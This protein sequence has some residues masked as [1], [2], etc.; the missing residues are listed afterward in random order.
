MSENAID[1]AEFKATQRE[2]WGDAASGWKK[3]WR[4]FEAAASP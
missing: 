1:P 3:W 4:V 2:S